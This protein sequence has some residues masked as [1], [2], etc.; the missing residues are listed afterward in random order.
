MI[1]RSLGIVVF[2]FFYFCSTSVF[3]VKE[4]FKSLGFIDKLQDPLSTLSTLLIQFFNGFVAADRIGAFLYLPESYVTAKIDSTAIVLKNCYFNYNNE[5]NNETFENS[6]LKD[7]SLEIQKGQKIAIIGKTGSGKSSI[8]R[9]LGQTLFLK[10]GE[11]TTFSTTSIAN[12]KPWLFD[13]TVRDNIILDKPYEEEYYLSILDLCCLKEDLSKMEN[14]DLTR[15]AQKGSNFST[16]QR[17]RIVLARCLYNRSELLLID[18]L[19]ANIDARS[20]QKIAHRI[21]CC[22]FKDQ[23]IVYVASSSELLEKAD[24]IIHMEDGRVINKGT[25]EEM[26]ERIFTEKQT[27]CEDFNENNVVDQEKL[28]IKQRKTR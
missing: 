1:G 16:G 21:F 24:K 19:F 10:A 25:F 26:K 4:V 5:E 11:F 14:W 3:N 18:D 23:T 13:G 12:E 7:I 8:L 17:G 22:D 6:S 27:L 15:V 2:F 20:R 9:A 28:V